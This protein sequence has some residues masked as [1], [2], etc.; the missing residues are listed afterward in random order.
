MTHQAPPSNEQTVSLSWRLM[1]EATES[2]CSRVCC[3]AEA[4]AHYEYPYET[5]HRWCDWWRGFA[6]GWMESALEACGTSDLV[7]NGNL[8][9]EGMA[10]QELHTDAH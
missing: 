9:P 10:H 3:G 5:W 4:A 8:P 6:E 2:A 7:E 1:K